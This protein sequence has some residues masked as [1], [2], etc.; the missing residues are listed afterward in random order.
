MSK[1]FTSIFLYSIEIAQS[2]KEYVW[3]IPSDHKESFSTILALISAL[4]FGIKFITKN[5]RLKSTFRNLTFFSEEKVKSYIKYYINH[6]F[7]F[8]PVSSVE[9]E[10]KTSDKISLKK[11]KKEILGPTNDDKFYIILAES[12][13]GKTALLINLLYKHYSIWNVYKGETFKLFILNEEL[14]NSI[15][16]YKEDNRHFTKQFYYWMHWTKTHWPGQIFIKE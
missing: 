9:D 16:K 8:T 11:F 10:T 1:L 14:I 7:S 15:E 4:F 2:C 5:Q 3:S 13:M 12:G 6:K